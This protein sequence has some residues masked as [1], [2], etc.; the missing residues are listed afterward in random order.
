MMEATAGTSN[1]KQKCGG[2]TTECGLPPDPPFSLAAS[3]HVGAVWELVSCDFLR[4]KHVLLIQLFKRFTTIKEAERLS[5]QSQ[6][7]TIN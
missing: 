2:K 6:H 5:P 1:A 4:H 3:R 7:R